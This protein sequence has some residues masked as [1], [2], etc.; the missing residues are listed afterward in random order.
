M[1]VRQRRRTFRCCGTEVEWCDSFANERGVDG[2]NIGR[3]DRLRYVVFINGLNDRYLYHRIAHHRRVD[4]DAVLA[5]LDR[6][7]SPAPPDLVVGIE[8]RFK[9]V[10][11]A[12]LFG[13]P[14][15]DF[16]DLF[17][18]LRPAAHTISSWIHSTMTKSRPSRSE[19]AH[20]SSWA[21]TSQRLQIIASL[22]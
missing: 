16:A 4:G 18:D 12:P 6:L 7:A 14:Y 1:I 13:V 11:L 22:R 15:Q 5:W 21:R 10:E 17:G 8:R 2:G 19:R 3:R 9:L 20:S